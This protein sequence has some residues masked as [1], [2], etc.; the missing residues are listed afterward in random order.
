MESKTDLP[1]K[2]VSKRVGVT[3]G[4]DSMLEATNNTY[5]GTNTK[6]SAL[7]IYLMLRNV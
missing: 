6:V 3:V 7:F 4:E 1:V 2:K 5:S